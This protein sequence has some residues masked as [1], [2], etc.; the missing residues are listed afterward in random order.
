MSTPDLPGTTSTGRRTARPT[1]SRPD[2]TTVAAVLVPV[3][4]LLAVLLVDTGE[5]AT[6]VGG[7]PD[8]LALTRSTVVCPPG[9]G[10]VQVATTS[11]ASGSV[12][13]RSGEDTA[14][15]EV[16]PGTLGSV[17]LG[18]GA[19]VLTGEGDLAPGLVAG[20]FETPPATV[21]CRA[22][23]FEQWF[24]GVGAGAGHRSA[25]RLV[26]PDEGRAVLDVTVL[27][28]SGVVPAPRLRGITVEG[29]ETRTIRLAEELPR[30]DELSLHVTV[31]RG[32]I[33]AS[34]LDTTRDLEETRS[35]DDGLGSQ[36][37]PST[38]NLLLGVPDATGPRTLVLANPGDVQARA[39]VSLVT[40]DAVFVPAGLDEVVL[41]PQSVVT[42]PVT[43]VL[44]S[45]G[46]GDEA[47]VG[48]SVE[49]TVPLTS[50]LSMFVRGD[51]ATTVP[52]PP[53]VG[54]ATTVLPGG[55]QQLVLGDARSS[56]VVSVVARDAEG[57][58]LSEERVEVAPGRADTL[59][60]PG[61]ARL[62]TVT[63][64]R[65]SVA[66]VVRVLTD[67]GAT[68]VRLRE[69][70]TTGLVPDVRAGRP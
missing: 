60:L 5:T 32:R 38:T 50:S 18:E 63:P 16:G 39:T 35:G 36:D 58:V 66:A 42:V 59:D 10:T 49:S 6:R 28:S 48:L 67:S 11:D 4:A 26:N 53:L 51:L 14:P 57:T 12:T 62:V 25:L 45:A 21:E 47:A 46:T 24:T 13:A 34:V 22:P 41:E 61:R 9:G 31:D 70:A 52:V 65:T 56:G 20:R 55:D 64:S 44:R 7:A 69:A 68:V 54:S 37:A 33:A 27:G 8:E 23:E 3:L 19:V 17:R 1:R 29:G 40:R 30:T 43:Q 2:V 15:A